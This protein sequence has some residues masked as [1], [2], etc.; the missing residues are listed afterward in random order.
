MCFTFTPSF[1]RLLCSWFASLVS[2]WK[3]IACALF[4]S[5]T[6]I[7]NRATDEDWN[8]RRSFAPTSLICKSYTC[9]RNER[10]SNEV[11]SAYLQCRC[12]WLRCVTGWLL[13]LDELII[14][15]ADGLG[16]V[17]G[18]RSRPPIWMLRWRFIPFFW[19][20]ARSSVDI[21]LAGL[22]YLECSCY[23]HY[24]TRLI[25]RYVSNEGLNGKNVGFLSR[26]CY[27]Y[28]I[29]SPVRISF[30]ILISIFVIVIPLFHLEFR[31]LCVPR[32]P[33]SLTWV[34]VV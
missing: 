6:F 22:Y 17:T 29:S 19:L 28:A 26:L 32:R 14:Q 1:T 5:A 13:L 16:R 23:C 18:R 11:C 30:R 8:C 15:D 7:L 2:T 33:W 25:S 10:Y 20:N 3:L 24:G 4:P 34:M 27:F 31:P 12:T 9:A 21:R